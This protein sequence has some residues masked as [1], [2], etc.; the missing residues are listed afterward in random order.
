M[1]W[2]TI[3]EY[4]SLTENFVDSL[5]DI[6]YQ[7]F[8]EQSRKDTFNKRKMHKNL[9]NNYD[10]NK[11]ARRQERHKDNIGSLDL[12]NPIEERT[13]NRRNSKFTL[14]DIDSSSEFAWAVPI[15]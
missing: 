14:V 1:N 8:I 9:Y 7:Y 12:F 3:L 5:E 11:N 2:K 6:S 4:S 15:K 13:K 10:T